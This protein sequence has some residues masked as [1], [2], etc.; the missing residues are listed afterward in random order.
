MNKTQRDELI[1]RRLSENQ[2]LSEIQ[3]ELENDHQLSMTYMELRMLV[4]DLED[5]EWSKPEA[6]V[7]LGAEDTTQEVPAEAVELKDEIELNISSIVR[8]GCVLSGDVTFRSG[9]KA[10]WYVDQFGRMG[11]D[12]KGEQTPTESELMEF[13]EAL[14]KQVARRGLR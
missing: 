6:P 8:P 9:I 1:I 10:D 13:Q 2:S 4:A 12:P 7:D 5:V 14:Q 11:M 3:K